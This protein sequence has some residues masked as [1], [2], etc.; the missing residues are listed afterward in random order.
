MGEWAFLVQ[1]NQSVHLLSD[2]FEHIEIG[3]RLQN[4]V[5]GFCFYFEVDVVVTVQLD[6]AFY[7]HAV[8]LLQE[9]F[10]LQIHRL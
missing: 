7:L 2:A 6:D 1:L 5:L 10:E 8:F 4:I 9:F 3:S